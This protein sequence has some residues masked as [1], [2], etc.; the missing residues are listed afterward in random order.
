MDKRWGDKGPYL[1]LALDGYSPR[2]M[3]SFDR[4]S[5]SQLEATGLKGFFRSGSL[6]AGVLAA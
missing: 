1:S 4:C 2:E 5:A 3:L 6:W